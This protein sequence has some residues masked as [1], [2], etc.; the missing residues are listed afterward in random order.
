MISIRYSDLMLTIIAICFVAGTAGFLFLLIRL[1]SALAE[2]RLLTR[3]AD[4]LLPQF[5]R[6]LDEVEETKKTLRRILKRTDEVT[7]NIA[8][9]TSEVR[10]TVVPLV[11]LAG[12]CSGS[13][14]KLPALLSGLQVGLSKLFRDPEKKEEKQDNGP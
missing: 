9:V 12:R 13:L 6:I 11:Q 4:A 14:K 7:E 2:W 1:G 10:Q 5:Q 8:S 3:K